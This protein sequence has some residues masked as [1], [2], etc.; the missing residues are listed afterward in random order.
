MEQQSVQEVQYA[1]D[2]RQSLLH[3][4]RVVPGSGLWHFTVE[5]VT[6]GDLCVSCF[7]NVRTVGDYARRPRCT[8]LTDRGIE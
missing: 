4:H 7:L 6:P 8:S 2:V 3:R 1:S 5:P